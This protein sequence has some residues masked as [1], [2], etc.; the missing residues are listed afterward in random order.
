[1]TNS[2]IP[3]SQTTISTRGTVR[4]IARAF[5]DL[6]ISNKLNAGLAVLLVVVV[7]AVG[8]SAWASSLATTDI[9]RMQSLR[10]PTALTSAQAQTHLLQVLADIRSYLVLGDLEFRSAYSRDIKNFEADLAK[11]ETLSADWTNPEN[12]RRLQELQSTFA[13]WSELPTQMFVLHDSALDNQPARRILIQQAEPLFDAILDDI[14][15]MIKEQAQRENIA[16]LKDMADFQSTFLSLQS[17]LHGYLATDGTLFKFDYRLTLTANQ[18]AWDQ[19]VNQRSSLSLDQAARLDDIAHS[20]ESLLPLPQQIFDVL[21]SGRAYED[22]FLLRTKAVP[23]ADVMLGLLDEMKSDQQ[24]LLQADLD[25]GS[26]RLSDARWQT[27]VGGL[28]ALVFGLGLTFVFRQGVAAPIQRLTG[29][30]AQIIAGDLNAQAPVESGDEIGRLAETFNTMTS[31]LRQTLM[32][33]E[34]RTRDTEQRSR[35]LEAS[36]EV[37]HAAA[38]ILESDQLIR[39]V[40]ELILDQF[41]LYYVGLFLVDALGEWAVLQA[42]T[43]E[44][45]RAMLARGHRIQ[46][47]EGMIG[48]SVANAQARVALEVGQD[49]VRKPTA[50]LPDTRSEAAIPLRSRDRVVGALTVQHTR[51]GAF[52]P[53]T[54]A[55]LQSMADQVAVALENAQLLASSQA[56]LEAERRAYGE[57]SR[58]GWAQL[59]RGGLSLGYHY[60]QGNIIPMAKSDLAERQGDDV[61]VSQPA[62]ALPK[63]TL[64]IKIHEHVVGAINARKPGE[65]GEWTAEEIT[66]IEMLSGQLSQALE[67]ARLYQ[68]TQDRAVR[69]Q[70]IGEVTAHIRAATSV[71][72]AVQ[73]AVHEM[74]RALGA[75]ELVARIG[76][77]QYLLPN[78]AQAEVEAPPQEEESPG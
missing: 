36:A 35:Y 33:L 20:R 42:G 43:G 75:T 4:R 54:V 30:A 53:D 21:E 8:L 70:L 1:M 6:S 65:A 12:A 32:N 10:V 57:V 52:D 55:V 17:A 44:A 61:Q 13:V 15:G 68:N 26:R 73:R 67:N 18:F 16:L 22:L 62:E 49:A 59:T 47:G 58:K 31:Q 11:M 51:P 60:G 64:P 78:Q 37:S 39:Q 24:L 3:S 74:G 34:Q 27:L 48:W 25:S 38:S 7:L 46:V 9:N 63:L 50:E 66:L 77:K 2:N 29:V 69:E 76:T 72:D 28:V 41:E 71:E 56:A 19:L 40:V 5:G 45:G 14:A 23:L